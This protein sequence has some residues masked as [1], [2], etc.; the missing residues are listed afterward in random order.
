MAICK[1]SDSEG[2]TGWR[3]DIQPGGRGSKRFRKTFKTQAEAKQW[4]AL[5]TTQVNQAAQKGRAPE[6]RDTRRLSEL[7]STWYE[8]HG[9]GLRAGEGVKE[10]TTSSC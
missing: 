4:E 7:V 1:T 5:L 10:A 3:V 2:K 9:R 8:T 6:K